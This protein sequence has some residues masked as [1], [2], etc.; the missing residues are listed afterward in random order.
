MLTKEIHEVYVAVECDSSDKG[1]GLDTVESVTGITETQIITSDSDGDECTYDR[2]DGSFVHD[3]N[4]RIHESSLTQFEALVKG[5]WS[6]NRVWP[7][8]EDMMDALDAAP[9]DDAE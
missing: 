5:G 6:P 7:S 8:H 1:W 4:Y 3:T 9:R 2:S